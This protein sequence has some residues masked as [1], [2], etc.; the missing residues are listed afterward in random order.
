MMFIRMSVVLFRPWAEEHKLSG[1]SSGQPPRY[2]N[3]PGFEEPALA[4]WHT[5][6]SSGRH[7]TDDDSRPTPWDVKIIQGE[8]NF[9][10]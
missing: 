2:K 6:Y 8:R 4:V 5:A 3:A 7:C 9:Q 1:E 10:D